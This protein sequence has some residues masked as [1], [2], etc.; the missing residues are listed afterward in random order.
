MQDNFYRFD[1]NYPIEYIEDLLKINSESVNLS[2]ND[3]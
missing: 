2:N 1:K 3:E